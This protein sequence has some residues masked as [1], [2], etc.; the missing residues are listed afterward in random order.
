M[1]KSLNARKC[2][3]GYYVSITKTIKVIDK[4]D[5]MR[6]IKD[7]KLNYHKQFSTENKIWADERKFD[8]GE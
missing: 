3:D 6:L 2:K 1:S 4:E 5:V 8:L 7:E